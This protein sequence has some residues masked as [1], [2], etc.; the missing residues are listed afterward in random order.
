MSIFFAMWVYGSAIRKGRRLRKLFM[1]MDAYYHQ[2]LIQWK[3]IGLSVE[4]LD[5]HSL[6]GN[7]KMELDQLLGQLLTILSRPTYASV[8]IP[9]QTQFFS[10]IQL[11]TESYFRSPG[12]KRIKKF[13]INAQKE[14][15]ALMNEQLRTN[16]EN[17][18]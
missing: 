9:Y 16:I 5:G 2:F 12:I 6:F 15:M 13:D 1:E 4:E 14:Y 11:K 7:L 17:I 8:Y 3:E 10:I 18:V